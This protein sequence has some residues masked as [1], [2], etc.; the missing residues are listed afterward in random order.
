M[1][2]K[3]IRTSHKNDEAFNVNCDHKEQRSM[4]STTEK[5]LRGLNLPLT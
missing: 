3:L 2:M 1:M 4:K 5:F